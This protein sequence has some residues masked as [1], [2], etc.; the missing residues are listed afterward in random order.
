MLWCGYVLSLVIHQF[1]P[2]CFTQTDAYP[3]SGDRVKGTPNGPSLLPIKAQATVS[4]VMSANGTSSSHHTN[5]LRQVSESVGGR[6]WTNIDVYQ[7]KSCMRSGN[8]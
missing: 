7:V 2:H 1:F 5:L 3:L 4:G 6:N 8:G